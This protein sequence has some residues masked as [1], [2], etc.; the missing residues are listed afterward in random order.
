MKSE[1]NWR[2]I[3]IREGRDF[4][5]KIG[6]M[7]ATMVEG[8]AYRYWGDTYFRCTFAENEDGDIRQIHANGY[9]TRDITARKGIAAT[10]GHDTFRR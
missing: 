7:H 10:F 4:R 6:D 8:H 9:I 2:E 5:E 1:M 3:K